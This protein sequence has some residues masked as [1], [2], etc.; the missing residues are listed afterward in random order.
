VCIIPHVASPL[1][2]A[3]SPLK[4]YEYLAAGKPVAAT[5]LPPVSGVSERVISARPEDFVAAVRTA[6][7]QPRQD[8]RDRREFL[9]SN[10]W[11]ARHER[12]VRVLLADDTN[13]WTI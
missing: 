5:D 11:D 13:W 10:S 9:R 2:R 4:L 7:D 8:E 1:T 6:L 3:M 12:T